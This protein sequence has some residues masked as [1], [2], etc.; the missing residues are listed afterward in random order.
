MSRSFAPLG[1]LI[2]SLFGM[3]VIP[4]L[5]QM[6]GDHRDRSWAA[7]IAGTLGAAILMWLFGVFAYAAAPAASVDPGQYAQIL[8]A[9]FRWLIPVV[10]FL[11][12]FTSFITLM[13][14]LK[15]ML[16]YDAKLKPQAAWS[17]A[18]M[19]PLVLLL[20]MHRDFLGTI[21]LVGGVF[22]AINGIFACALGVV[23]LKRRWPLIPGG[24][25]LLILLSR[26]LSLI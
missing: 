2:F 13:E 3:T 15:H 14:A 9:G 10:G 11:A 25:F 24:I 7:I 8:P 19:S 18:L 26:I 20:I 4:E 1:I 17:I 12:V 22:S 5:V 23:I 6:T 16:I 21:S